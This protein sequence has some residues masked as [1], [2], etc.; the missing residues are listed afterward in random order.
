MGCH[1]CGTTERDLRPYGPGGSPICHPCATATPERE[2][3]THAAFDAQLEAM[4]AITPI[5]VIGDEE[6]PRPLR[7]GDLP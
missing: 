1:Y 4:G 6:G 5:V 3:A 2:A 7:P